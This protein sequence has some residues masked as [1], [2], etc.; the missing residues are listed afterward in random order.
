MKSILWGATG[1]AKVVRPIL[2][3][4]GHEVVA[5]FDNDSNVPPPF[6]DVP[7]YHGEESFVR[8]LSHMKER[9]G[10]VTA[11]GGDR[12]NVRIEISRRLAAAGLEPLSIVHSTAF[13]AGTAKLGTGVQILAMAAICE[14]AD[15][16]DFSIVNTN[17]T[18]DHECVIGNGCHVMPAA[19]LAGEVILGDFTTIGTNA[20]VLPRM[21]IGCS[22]MVGAG[23]VVTRDVADGVTVKGVPAQAAA[24]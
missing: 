20:T 7:L 10:F 11:I 5:V 12:G 16:G 15:I 24:I 9:L 4:A 3:Q 2:E 17:A 6:P 22:V 21:R 23:A 1:Q 14:Y 19:A 18:V 8:F 13:V